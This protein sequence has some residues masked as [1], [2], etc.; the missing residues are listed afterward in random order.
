M[1]SIAVSVVV[2]DQ[3]FGLDLVLLKHAD[4]LN[5]SV[6]ANPTIYEGSASLPHESSILPS[7]RT[8][9]RKHPSSLARP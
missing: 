1:L 7:L 6:L 8:I 2:H 9:L 4:S 3:M 5:I